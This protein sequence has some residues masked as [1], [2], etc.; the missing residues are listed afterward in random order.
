LELCTESYLPCFEESRDFSISGVSSERYML[1][2]LTIEETKQL[3]DERIFERCKGMVGIEDV[4]G[5]KFADSD[6]FR[7]GDV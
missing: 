3:I 1:R 7:S 6:R 4:A 2:Q 5:S